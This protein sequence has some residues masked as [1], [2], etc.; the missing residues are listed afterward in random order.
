M[1]LLRQVN[2]SAALQ[3]LNTPWNWHRLQVLQ[4]VVACV[5]SA[6][7]L[8]SQLPLVTYDSRGVGHLHSQRRLGQNSH[9]IRQARRFF[10]NATM[11]GTAHAPRNLA[12]SS[13]WT[14]AVA[15]SSSRDKLGSEIAYDV[16]TDVR[17][18]QGRS[19]AFLHANIAAYMFVSQC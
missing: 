7:V 19:L 8:K 12:C 17:K 15:I 5:C 11:Q 16:T 10:G 4:L 13:C 6:M 2:M 14:F 18:L 3:H 1:G 9:H